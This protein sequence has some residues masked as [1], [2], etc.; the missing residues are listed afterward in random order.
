MKKIILTM[1]VILFPIFSPAWAWV[2]TGDTNIAEVVQWEEERVTYAVLIFSSG[3]KCYV[4][5][6]D[7][8]L[9]SLALS[10]FVSGKKLNLH[11]YDAAENI[12]GYSAHKVHRVNA[13][14]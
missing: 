14:G 11:C 2:Q 9:Y 3:H 6:K 8:A 5:T 4:S 7:E 13:K 10:M 12:G 1:F